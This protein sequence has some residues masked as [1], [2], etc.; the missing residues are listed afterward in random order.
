MKFDDI[1]LAMDLL[2]KGMSAQKLLT[3]TGTFKNLNNYIFT[4][5]NNVAKKKLAERY[6]EEIH[7]RQLELNRNSSREEKVTAHGSVTGG[8]GKPDNSWDIISYEDDGTRHHIN[9]KTQDTIFTYPNHGTR[10]N[11]RYSTPSKAPPSTREF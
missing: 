9:S 1:K 4:Q 2:N 8:N 5:I 10:E 6:F 7:K 3:S 11:R